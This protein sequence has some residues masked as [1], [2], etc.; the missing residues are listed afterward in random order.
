MQ[1]DYPELSHHQLKMLGCSQHQKYFEHQLEGIKLHY[2][3][4][5]LLSK[6]VTL[7]PQDHV[8]IHSY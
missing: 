5:H 2:E 3:N 4:S 6:I 8:V 7:H 1:V